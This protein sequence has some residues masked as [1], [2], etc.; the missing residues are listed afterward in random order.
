MMDWLALASL[1]FLLCTIVI[2]FATKINMGIIAIALAL[3][4]ARLSGVTDGTVIKGFNY[5]LFFILTGV[6]LLF[7]IAESNG[8]LAL[9]AD[10]VLVLCGYRSYL[11]PIFIFTL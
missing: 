7:S 8:T 6:T 5:S 1:G 4:L 3:L 2:G 9:F 10:K 11:V